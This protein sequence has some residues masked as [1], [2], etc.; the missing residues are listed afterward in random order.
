MPAIHPSIAPTNAMAATGS[1]RKSGD[2]NTT[3]CT[4]GQTQY[5]NQNQW[6]LRHGGC[7]NFVRKPPTQ[8]GTSKTPALRKIASTANN[9]GKQLNKETTCKADQTM[10]DQAT[11]N[12]LVRPQSHELPAMPCV[13][14]RSQLVHAAIMSKRSPSIDTSAAG[15]PLCSV[16]VSSSTRRHNRSRAMALALHPELCRYP[17]K[18]RSPLEEL[19]HRGYLPPGEC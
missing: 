12:T 19:S 18:N 14:L 1:Q 17:S 4:R 13:K 7:A 16:L 15:G 9:A 6:A 10:A 2:H 11:D 8:A 5:R 3:A